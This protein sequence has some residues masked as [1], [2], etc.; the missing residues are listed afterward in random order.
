MFCAEATR[1]GSL[2]LQV[3]EEEQEGWTKLRSLIDD[4][5]GEAK[6][7]LGTHFKIGFAKL[8]LAF[9]LRILLT[10]WQA[11]KNGRWCNPFKTQKQFYASNSRIYST[12]MKDIYLQGLSSLLF[13]YEVALISLCPGRVMCQ[14]LFFS[15][16][17]P[18]VPSNSSTK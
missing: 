11:L 2:L 1:P 18:T 6:L 15:Q 16:Y 9:H 10:F 3:L 4:R 7:K 5:C 14:L 17:D 8:E 13:S 12:C